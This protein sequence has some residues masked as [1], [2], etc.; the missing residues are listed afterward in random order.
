LNFEQNQFHLIGELFAFDD[1]VSGAANNTRYTTVSAYLQPEYKLGESG[2]T[3]VYGRVE[4]TPHAAQGGY[5]KL[6]P[7][8]SPHQLVADLR[9]DITPSQAI[10]VEAARSHR[11]DSLEFN[12]IS[13][14]WSMVLPL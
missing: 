8:F 4:S 2:R 13:A 1:R 9:F 5:L 11:Q 3:T 12:S 14:Q 7:E 6:L 10:K